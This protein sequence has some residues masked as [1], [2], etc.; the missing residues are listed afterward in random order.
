MNV[1]AE[2]RRIYAQGGLR[3]AMEFVNRQGGH[4]FSAVLKFDAGML[5]SLC[6]VD[7]ENPGAERWEEIPVEA[8]YCVFVRDSG[9]AVRINDSLSDAR[10]VGHPKR[11]TVRAYYGHPLVDERGAVFGTICH[12]DVVPRDAHPDPEGLMGVLGDLLQMSRRPT[13]SG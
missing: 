7:R 1:R 4:R 13:Q 8:S 2:L 3:P 12:F 9:R 5:K 6:L 10:A 11:Q